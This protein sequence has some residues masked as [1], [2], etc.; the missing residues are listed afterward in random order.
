MSKVKQISNKTNI[1]EAKDDL[2]FFNEGDYIT[3]EMSQ[4]A[5]LLEQY[6]ERL[7]KENEEYKKQYDSLVE[8][9]K[10]DIEEYPEATYT[11][12][13]LLDCLELLDTEK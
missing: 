3:R 1:E 5:K 12:Y 13:Y 7:E 4:S 8:K 2:R 9:I 10:K 11:K 6:I